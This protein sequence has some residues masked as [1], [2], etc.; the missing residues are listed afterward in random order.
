VG[1]PQCDLAQAVG[2]GV[3]FGLAFAGAVDFT[4]AVSFA[5]AVF[6]SHV[7][8]QPFRELAAQ[9]DQ[10]MRGQVAPAE[11]AVPRQRMIGRDDGFERHLHQLARF[12][13]RGAVAFGADAEIR[14]PGE[15]A[16]RHRFDRRI[17]QAYADVRVARA[18]CRDHLRQQGTGHQLGYGD[19]HDALSELRLVR[20]VR[21]RTVEIVDHLAE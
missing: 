15:H 6:A 17:G 16:R 2:P 20:N 10:R 18:P 13:L 7:G 5:A 8:Q 14:F 3:A 21:K 11:P 9:R 19:A 1:R 12:Q 4:C